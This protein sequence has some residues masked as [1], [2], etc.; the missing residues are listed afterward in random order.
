M[1]ISIH[2]YLTGVP[3]RIK[4]LEALYDYI[5][6]HDGVVDVDWRRDPRLV[7]HTDFAKEIVAQAS[8][9]FP[10]ADSDLKKGSAPAA[11]IRDTTWRRG[12][13]RSALSMGERYKRSWLLTELRNLPWPADATHLQHETCCRI[14]KIRL[15]G[16][17]K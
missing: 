13:M 9:G 15:S 17:W 6:G 10:V 8:L 5:L 14:L 12:R 1:A 16:S 3:H 11:E 2:L 4:Y 7:S